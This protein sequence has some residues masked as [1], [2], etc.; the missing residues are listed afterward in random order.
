M[1]LPISVL[2]VLLGTVAAHCEPK[3]ILLV[4][5]EVTVKPHGLQAQSQV[6][7]NVHGPTESV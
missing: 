6:T 4:K 5:W 2:H 3:V 1:G 7:V